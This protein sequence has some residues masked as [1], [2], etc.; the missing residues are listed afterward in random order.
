[1]GRDPSNHDKVSLYL[2]NAVCA[3]L[4]GLTYQS[5]CIAQLAHEERE[6]LQTMLMSEELQTAVDRICSEGGELTKISF[7][8][9]AML[10]RSDCL[11]ILAASLPTRF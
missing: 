8:R 9:S 10:I 7:I 6:S 4:C 1:M 5:L 11:P 3:H 2:K